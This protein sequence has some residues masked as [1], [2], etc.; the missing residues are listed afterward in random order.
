M[1]RC[2]WGI[3]IYVPHECQRQ[4]RALAFVPELGAIANGI[5]KAVGIVPTAAELKTVFRIWR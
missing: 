2:C 5:K 4:E 3:R 1:E